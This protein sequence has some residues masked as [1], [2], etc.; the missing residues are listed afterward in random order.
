MFCL[1]MLSMYRST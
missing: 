1:T